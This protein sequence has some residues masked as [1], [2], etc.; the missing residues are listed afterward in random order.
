MPELVLSVATLRVSSWS[1][2][3]WLALTHA[4]ADFETRTAVVDMVH[5]E[6]TADSLQSEAEELAFRRGLGSV[7]GLFPV[8]W[9]D[10]RPIHESLAICEWAAEAYPAAGLWP[11]DAMDRA[12]AR[13][14]SC[15]MAAGFPL[16]REHLSCHP[17]ARVPGFTPNPATQLEIH[18]VFELWTACLERSGGPFLFGAFG[19]VDCMY[20]PVVTRFATYGVALPPR[21]AAYAEAVMQVPAVQAWR[22]LALQSP[23]IPH[24][25]DN[26]IRL[27]GDPDAAA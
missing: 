13:S 27:G 5:H 9:V 24:Y 19:I 10:G 18:R 23:R 21:L 4:G 17:F 6:V 16:L 2:R 14:L 11:A 7:T 22:A 3:P 8:L 25:D 12:Q 26:I 1:I 15:E 20:F